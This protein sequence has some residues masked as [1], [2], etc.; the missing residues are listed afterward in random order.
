MEVLDR[1]AILAA[2]FQRLQ[3]ATQRVLLLDYDGTLAPFTA[4]RAQAFPYPEVPPLLRA[5][6]RTGTRVVLVTGRPSRELVMLSGLYP[7][8]EIWGS[9]GLERL[10]PDGDYSVVTLPDEEGS[11]LSQAADLARRLGLERNLELKPGGAAIH[12]RGV[13][14][15]EAQKI[16]NQVTGAWTPQVGNTPCDY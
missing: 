16:K 5:I 14:S 3:T 4:D 2:F 12:W 1:E 15:S 6:M 7:H 13:E 10:K 11:A 9:H 8:P